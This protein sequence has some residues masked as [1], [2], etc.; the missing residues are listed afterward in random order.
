MAI[1]H[2]VL[3]LLFYLGV[4]DT[5]VGYFLDFELPAWLIA[6]LDGSAAYLLWVGYRRGVSDPVFGL[7]A[8][9]IAAVIMLGRALWFVVIPVLV[10]VVISGSLGRVIRSTRTTRDGTLLASG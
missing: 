6:A 4:W 5:G 3:T 2:V 7:T 8:T 10:V 9:A 1:V